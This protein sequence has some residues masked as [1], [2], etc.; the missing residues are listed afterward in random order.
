MTLLE[1]QKMLGEEIQNENQY[2][3]MRLRD[4]Y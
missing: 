2:Y 1:L 4:E 3:R